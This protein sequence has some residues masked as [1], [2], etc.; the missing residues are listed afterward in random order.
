[1]KEG[2]ETMENL[3]EKIAAMQPKEQ[4]D[5]WMVGEQLKD[6]AR[7]SEETAE[8]LE[9]D[10]GVPEM[11]LKQAAAQLQKAADKKRGGMRG[12]SCVVITPAEA[13]A[14]LRRFYGIPERDAAPAP[15]KPGGHKV[16]DL[17]DM[18]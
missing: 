11:G 6:I 12:D 1:M 17:F 5:V 15:E 14:I 8:I 16:I 9:K 2:A 7:E 4:N 13:D 3:I 18:I 10:L